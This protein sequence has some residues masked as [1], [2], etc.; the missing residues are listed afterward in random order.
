V[1]RIAADSIAEHVAQQ[2]AAVFDAAIRLFVERGYAAVSLSDVA[3]EIGLARTSLYRY[4]PDKAHLLVRWLRRELP[5]QA[6]LARRRL[7]SEEPPIER[8]QGWAVDQLDYA[9]RPEHRLLAAL[10]Q[11]A[12][13][14]DDA[15]RAE[16]ADSHR[17][18]QLPL[19]DALADAGVADRAAGEALAALLG[20]MVMAVAE[21]ERRGDEAAVLR[22]RLLRAIAA[23][24]GEAAD[25][26]SRC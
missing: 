7:T 10:G 3:A 2:E 23:V 15:T 26:G 20:G 19:L 1:P 5:V 9:L 24:I 21:R 4:V 25:D 6:E 16:L 13:E 18:L 8:I 17:A 12:P 11:A 22:E 14:L